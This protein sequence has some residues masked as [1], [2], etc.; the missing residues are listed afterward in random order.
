MI[1]Q[2]KSTIIHVYRKPEQKCKKDERNLKKINVK[3]SERL[4]AL[5]RIME[6]VSP[7]LKDEYYLVAFP[8]YE[9]EKKNNIFVGTSFPYISHFTRRKQSRHLGNSPRPQSK[10]EISPNH[11]P[12]HVHKLPAVF[13]FIM[14]QCKECTG[15]QNRLPKMCHF[16]L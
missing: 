8:L 14:S 11:A 1:K 6:I 15:V 13:S 4:R 9:Q 7:F 5:T 3:N 2:H 10:K 12:Q 16:G